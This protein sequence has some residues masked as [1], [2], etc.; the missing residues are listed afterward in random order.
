MIE[1][2]IL[3]PCLNE[4]DSLA[5]CIQEARNCIERLH[6][7]AEILIAD[8]GSDDGSLDIARENG[9][10]V[11]SVIERGYGATLRGGIEAARG[12]YIIMGDS[13]GSYDFSSLDLFVEGLREGNSLVIG[14]RF[15]GGIERGAMPWIHKIGV[16]V[17]STVA[18]MR[19]K[20]KVYDFHC[21]LRAFVREEARNL[22]LTC[23][24]MEFATEII[25]K[26]VMTKAKILEVPTVL[27]KDKRCTS[28]RH[29]RTFRDGFRHLWYILL[30][31]S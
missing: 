13:D 9:A 15:K 29:L 19:F 5:F 4:A 8:N 11:I 14:N 17:L 25:A 16:P 20:C 22:E 27:R 24:G 26:F 1:F 7:E 10:R 23:S 12:Q 28:V 2:T 18:S 3:M 30:Y 21:G 6:L 31:R